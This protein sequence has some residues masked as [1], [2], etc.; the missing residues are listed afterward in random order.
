MENKK[1]LEKIKKPDPANKEDQ[2]EKRISKQGSTTGAIAV[3]KNIETILELD[4]EAVQ[5]R[6]KAEQIADKVTTFA[7]STPF[8]MLH[9]AWFGAWI[10]VNGGVIPGL[11]AF[12]PFPF[13]FLTLVV[14][15]EAIFLTLL[16]LMS[17]N[18]MTKE[19]DKRAQLDLQINML[20]EQESTMILRIVRKIAKH[21]GLDENDQF[22]KELS[23]ETD[24]NSL[25]Q[26][27]DDK[28]AST[29]NKLP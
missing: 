10:I 12:D 18:R 23:Q 16:V 8:I 3:K 22:V 2:K 13:S 20:D 27:L 7:G 25:A 9:V 15:L 4:K 26:K 6:S 1:K 24:V 21:L 19:A 17:Q 11:A 29:K 5:G 14:S 28:A